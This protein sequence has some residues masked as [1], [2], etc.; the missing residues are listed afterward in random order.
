M[1]PVLLAAA[2]LALAMPAQAETRTCDQFELSIQHR[3]NALGMRDVD[4]C[5]LTRMQRAALHMKLQGNMGFGCQRIRLKQEVK[6]IL[7][8]SDKESG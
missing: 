5:N 7:G 6:V 4:A 2:I 8:W 1:K 3:L